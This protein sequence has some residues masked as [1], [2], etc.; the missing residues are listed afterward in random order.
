MC[1]AVCVLIA[2]LS[3]ECVE[4]AS[5]RGTA[6]RSS[7]L[8][9]EGLA[10]ARLGN[11]RLRCSPALGSQ[12]RKKYSFRTLELFFKCRFESRSP[13]RVHGYSPA[14]LALCAQDA[15]VKAMISGIVSASAGF[16]LSSSFNGSGSSEC[17]KPHSKYIDLVA[18]WRLD[19]VGK[20]RT[21]IGQMLPTPPAETGRGLRLALFL[22]GFV[23]VVVLAGVRRKGADDNNVVGRLRSKKIP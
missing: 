15:G 21:S 4:M 11:H 13:N 10:V 19:V 20:N 7:P 8:E 12:Y 16:L 18:E 1:V 5:I 6:G 14:P 2:L 3:A 17:Q 22:A 9:H 23:A